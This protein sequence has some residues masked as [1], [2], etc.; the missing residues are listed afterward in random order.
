[1]EVIISGVTQPAEGSYCLDVSVG[2]DEAYREELIGFLRDIGGPFEIETLQRGMWQGAKILR[3]V[4]P[5]ARELRQHIYDGL[6][7]GDDNDYIIH[8]TLTDAER[9]FTWLPDYDTEY[10][11]MPF[12]LAE[13]GE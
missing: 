6:R 5:K 2:Y 11:H 1:M 10:G 4:T 3:I 9:C 7:T 13:R 12:C 8:V